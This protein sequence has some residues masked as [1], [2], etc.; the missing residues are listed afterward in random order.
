MCNLTAQFKYTK[1]DGIWTLHNPDL[2][3]KFKTSAPDGEFFLSIAPPKK[4]IRAIEQ[5]NYYWIICTLHG[6]HLGY[7]KEEMHACYGAELLYHEVVFN[8]KIVGV[9]K[10]TAKLNYSEMSEHIE[11]CIRLAAEDGVIIPALDEVK[12]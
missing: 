7:T 6:D 10:S 5:N 1:Q 9:I 11:H 8:G 12:L 2:L 4:S 3:N